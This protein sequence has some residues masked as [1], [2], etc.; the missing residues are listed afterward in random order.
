MLTTAVRFDKWLSDAEWGGDFLPI[1]FE[2]NN[3]ETVGGEEMVWRME[4][5]K[6]GQIKE[7]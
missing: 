1:F 6:M 4:K 7:V 2:E 5:R 3:V